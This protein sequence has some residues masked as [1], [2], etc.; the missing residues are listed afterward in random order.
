MKCLFIYPSWN[1]QMGYSEGVGMI[2]SCLK[3]AGHQVKLIQIN[4]NF[5]PLDHDKIQTMVRDYDPGI[6]LFSTGSNQFHYTVEIATRI[7]SYSTAPIVVGGPHPS[8]CPLE[9][10][11]EPSID[12]ICVGEGEGAV[13][14]LVSNLESGKDI[15]HIRNLWTKN[16]DRIIR[17]Q[18]RPFVDLDTLPY[19]DREAFEFQRMIDLRNG[20]VDVIA[21]RG[22]PYRCTY[23]FNENYHNIYKRELG[24][25][26]GAYVRYRNPDRL[27]QELL[28]LLRD[29]ER[30]QTFVFDDDTF[31][32]DKAWAS[33][34]CKLYKE[35]IGIPFVCN[36]NVNSLSQQIV[37][38]L[39]EANCF[40][41]RIGVECANENIR[42]NILKRTMTNDKIAR[43]IKMIK[44]HGIQVSTYNMIGMPTETK[45]DII[46]TLKLNVECSVDVIRIFTFYPFKNTPIYDICD[47]LGLLNPEAET[48]PNYFQRSVLSLPADLTSFIEDVQKNFCNY[49]NELCK[50]KDFRYERKFTPY[51]A[52]RVPK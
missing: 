1:T 31:A 38:C 51:F 14:E 16:S 4:E 8:L 12:I 41:M 18:V 9:S 32:M 26:C 47:Q 33:E 6:I 5:L 40:M 37:D 30:I 44:E 52:V 45:D 35:Q 36:A 19:A 43:T 10:I 50:D 46:N 13:V 17:N 20:W 21:G 3:K 2:I 28:Y 34:F 49:L 48:P 42:K 23:C 39:G 29:Y 11:V 22:C 27:V 25:G 24:V 7:K 15:T